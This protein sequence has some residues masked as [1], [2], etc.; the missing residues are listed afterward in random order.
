MLLTV[1][2]TNLNNLNSTKNDSTKDPQPT[3][4]EIVIKEV[5][6][7]TT[8]GTDH[9]T[10]KKEVGPVTISYPTE[11]ATITTNPV[12]VTIRY[13]NSEYC[14]VVW[15]YRVNEGEWSEYSSNSISLY[16]MEKWCKKNLPFA[17]KARLQMIQRYLSETLFI[18]VKKK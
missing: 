3:K 6:A 11:G 13:Q 17:F 5:P 4:Q 12:N 15:S 9:E 7:T 16:G 18:M 14:S 1:L 2:I 10:C 8:P